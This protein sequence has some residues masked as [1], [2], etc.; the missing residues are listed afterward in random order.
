MTKFKVLILGLGRISSLLEDDPFRYHPC[1]HTGTITSP[2]FS[3]YFEIFGFFDPN[4]DRT[5]QFKE[6]WARYLKTANSNLNTISKSKFDLCIIS[7]TSENHKENIEFA[8]KLKIPN[9][10]IEKPIV[11]NMDQL[12]ELEKKIKKSKTKVWVNHERRYHPVYKWVQK[13]LL[14]GNLGEI[15]TIKSSVLTSGNFPGIA[16][17]KEG[18]GPLLHDGTHAIDYMDYLFNEVPN[19]QYSQL[20]IPKT[21]KVENRAIAILLYQK[22][23][24]VFLEAGGERKYFQFEIDIQTNSHR[25]VLSNDGHRLFKAEK[26]TK[27]SGFKNLVEIEFPKFKNLNPWLFFYDEILLNLQGKS[28]IVLGNLSANKRILQTIQAIYSKSFR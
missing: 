21:Q 18:G 11:T 17:E 16:F 2:K 19:V 3:K 26:S 23:I 4:T 28:N 12:L 20:S 13:N 8:L 1:T 27:Y 9:L 25:I 14:E 5:N 7:S 24:Q 15:K 6:K 10:V 22:N